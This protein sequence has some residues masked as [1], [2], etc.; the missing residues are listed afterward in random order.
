MH[1]AFTMYSSFG[2]CFLK[3]DFWVQTFKSKSAV[4]FLRHPIQV[5]NN[6]FLKARGV[7]KSGLDLTLQ[8]V[9][10]FVA[11]FGRDFLE[12]L[13]YLVCGVARINTTVELVLSCRV[14]TT[15]TVILI[16]KKFAPKVWFE[17]NFEKS[18]G[19]KKETAKIKQKESLIYRRV[20][21]VSVCASVHRW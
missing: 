15:S 18:M 19:P 5:K 2:F 9:K 16:F 12:H 3:T 21:C 7:C 1:G 8:Q 20:M 4:V 14:T 13:F 17:D 6:S 10:S 11:I